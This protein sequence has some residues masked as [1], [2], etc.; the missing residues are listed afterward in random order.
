[1]RIDDRDLTWASERYA[2]DQALVEEA[3]KRVDIGAAVDVGPSDLLW[4]DVVDR[5]DDVA[6]VGETAVRRAGA[7]PEV[8]EVAML[9]AGAP[10]Q[11]D[12]RRL[13]VAM[14]EPAL[15][16]G[17]EGARDLADE[18]EGS[19]GGER[20]LSAKQ[21]LEVSACDVPHGYVEEPTGL[22]RLVHGD[23][24][25]V[26]ERSGE[27]RLSQESPAEPLVFRKLRREE[28]QRN[29][30]IQP[31]VVGE[32]HDAHAAAAEHAFDAVARELGADPVLGCD[33]HVFKRTT[34]VALPLG[35]R[36]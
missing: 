29:L 8:R 36:P 33:R 17:V 28:L 16:C 24:V 3:G 22:T 20:A 26:V 11:E 32:V 4:R 35:G 13:H 1:V 27:L 19:L 25:G 21:R 9:L 15:V 2:A 30:S 34:E 6:W 14:H 23:D 7:E 5:S 10:R 18:D 12:V 31:G